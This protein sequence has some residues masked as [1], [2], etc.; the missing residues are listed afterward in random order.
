MSVSTFVGHRAFLWSVALLL[1]A[2][3]ALAVG[4]SRVTASDGAE[5]NPLSFSFPAVNPCDGNAHTLTFDGEILVHVFA[6]E[7]GGQHV[8]STLQGAFF[9][10]DGFSGTTSRGITDSVTSSGVEVFTVGL[11][12]IMRNAE[13]QVIETSGSIQMKTVNGEVVVEDFVLTEDCHGRPA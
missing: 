7:S 8:H 4:S 2:A 11:T 10:S 12:N 1:L 9:S 5:W 13:H 3:A 6:D